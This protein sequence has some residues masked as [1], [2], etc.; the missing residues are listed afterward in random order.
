MK[1]FFISL[2]VFL[3]LTAALHALDAVSAWRHPEIAG[4]NSVFVD[5]GA[6]PVMFDDFEFNVLPLEIRADWLPPLPLPFSF[7]V[8]FKTPCPNLKS[9]GLRIGFHFDLYDPLTDFYLVYSF[10]FGFI[11]NGV[12]IEFNDEPVP[13]NYYD[14]RI[15]IRRFFGSWL[16]AAVETGFKFESVV[17]MLSLKI[18]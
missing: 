14:F 3:S 7:G 5:I 16:G 13:A 6:A 9:F 17:L 1:T 11:R 4:K 10:D 8:F 12:L 15:G 18:N 2:A